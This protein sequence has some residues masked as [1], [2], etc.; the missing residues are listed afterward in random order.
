MTNL[1][2][3]KTDSAEDFRSIFNGCE[4]LINLPPFTK[5]SKVKN[6]SYAFLGCKKIIA[7]PAY[8]YSAATDMTYAF[9]NC[10]ELI[11]FPA[12]ADF[13]RV[14]TFDSCWISD[15]KLET[16]PPNM[17]DTL[18]A[19]DNQEKS[20]QN[21][22]YNCALS[23]DSIEN[24]FDSI[25]TSGATG[26]I[27]GVQEGTN[28]PRFQGLAADAGSTLEWT[29]KAADAFKVLYYTK[30]RTVDGQASY[31]GAKGR[32]WTI[33]YNKYS[34]EV[35]DTPKT[36]IAHD[37]DSVRMFEAVSFE[38]GEKN[39]EEFSSK[40]DA[41]KRV[42]DLNPSYYQSWDPEKDYPIGSEVNINGRIYKALKNIPPKELL[43]EPTET[44][45][46]AVRSGRGWE[47]IYEP[48][49]EGL[50]PEE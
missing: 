44:A 11:S 20:M 17:F 14:N 3:F 40:R 48:P 21:A 43:I 50:L 29:Q 25:I 46:A 4:K 2:L 45:E 9:G 13:S 7:A 12:G 16:F 32:G 39:I 23:K 6:W 18:K 26:G 49:A 47:E 1:A 38:S 22:F 41:I 36:Y 42:L 10:I 8:D 30:G 35:K 37:G 15:Q 34:D 28:S 27:L 24:I 5:T 31:P 33:T 19:Q